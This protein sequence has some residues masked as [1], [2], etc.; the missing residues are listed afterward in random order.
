MSEAPQV[1]WREVM[2]K[3]GPYPIEAFGFVR[4]G[5][6]YTAQRVHDDF[7]ELADAGRHISGQ[8]L[9]MGLRDYAIDQYGML[10]PTVLSHWRIRRTDDFGRIVYAMIEA[11]LMT[12]TDADSID[13][14]R[15]VYDFRDA[16]SEDELRGAIGCN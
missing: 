4:E 8:E 7:E 14:F 10:A 5:L 3:A 13:D 16:F 11:G 1:D 15:A 6:S 12:Q 9:C 2:A